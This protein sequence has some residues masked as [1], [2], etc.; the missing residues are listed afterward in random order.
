[1]AKNSR[2]AG[3]SE[4]GRFEPANIAARERTVPRSSAEY[5][6]AGGKGEA[7]YKLTKIIEGSGKR[8]S[9]R[10]AKTGAF[11]PTKAAS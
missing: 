9:L 5:V 2:S 6:L 10:S 4:S 11:L 8:W 1:M 3:R 7:A